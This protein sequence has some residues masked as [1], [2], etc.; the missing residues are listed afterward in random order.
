MSV[1][2]ERQELFAKLYP[3][4]LIY[5]QLKGYQIRLGDTYA[6]EGHRENSNHYI[7]LAGDINL[8]KGG[9][10]LIL[11]DDHREFGEFWEKLHP[12]CR[13]GGRFDD[14][15]HYSIIYKGWI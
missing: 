2:G 9:K 14:G 8:F 6:R 5:I 4:L 3:Q 15:N 11:T 10:F 13:W 12:L 1:L 7:K